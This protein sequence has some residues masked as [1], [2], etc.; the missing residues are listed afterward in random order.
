MAQKRSKRIVVVSPHPDDETL[1]AGGTLLAMKR[2]GHRIYWLNFTNMDTKYGFDKAGVE[3]RSRE[4]AK[5]RRSYRFDGY[6]DLALKP[7]GLKEYRLDAVISKVA[8]VFRKIRPEV[9]IMPFRF[10]AHTDHGVVFDAVSACTKSFRHP[11]VR[12]VLL[13]EII[14]E[15]NF[16]S[17]GR[18]FAPNYFVDISSF[19]NKKIMIMRGYKGELKAHPFPRSEKAIRALALLR[20]TQAGCR[21]AEAFMLAKHINRGAV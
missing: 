1:G 10:D 19:I 13:M 16:S 3:R 9:V 17:R 7:S 6:Y 4:I 11:Y 18:Q 2:S 21:Y 14:S 5:A 8:Q 15:T 12:T 20:G